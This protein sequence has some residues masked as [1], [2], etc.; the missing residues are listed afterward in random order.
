MKIPR[1]NFLTTSTAAGVSALAFRPLALHAQEKLPLAFSTLGCP[2][3]DWP[4]ILDSAH[5]YGYAAIELRGLKGKMDLP[6]QP[7]FTPDQIAKRKQELAAHGL[8]LACVSSSTE[9]HT[10][11]P[12]K[13]AKTL[14]DGKR[15]IDLASALSAPY[16]RV[17]GNKIDGP[18]D[19]VLAR[20]VAGLQELGAYA[21]TRNV[22]VILESHGDFVDSP[23]LKAVL[24]RADS[25]NVGLLW[26]AHHTF[27]DGHESPEQTVKELGK[28]IRHTQLKDSVLNG[29]ERKY[30]QTGTGEVPIERQV[31]ALRKIG[32]KA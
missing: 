13:R 25:Q 2:G 22:V 4:N 3:W 19:E 21:G 29:T 10:K 14:A 23:T 9:L 18:R 30:V 20:V 5:S 15:F 7:E 8:K 26:D 27:V 12:D 6:S 17:F 28:W 11:D 16:V 1:R 32:Y 24:T 31:L